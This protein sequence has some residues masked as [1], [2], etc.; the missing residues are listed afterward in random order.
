MLV[1]I[2]QDVI[3]LETKLATYY[4][5]Y[6]KRKESVFNER[7]NM[8]QDI[9]ICPFLPIQ[10]AYLEKGKKSKV[11]CLYYNFESKNQNNTHTQ[12]FYFAAL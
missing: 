12:S 2:T 10:E 4:T 3:D 6:L 9:Q 8:E 11:H 1:K 5:S 7:R